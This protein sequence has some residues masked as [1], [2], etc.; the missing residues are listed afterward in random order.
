MLLPSPATKRIT[1]SRGFFLP[2]KH[3][4]KINNVI[5]LSRSPQAQ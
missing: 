2:T 1:A 3:L 4:E 5:S